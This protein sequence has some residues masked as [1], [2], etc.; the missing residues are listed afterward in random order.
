MTSEKTIKAAAKEME[1][2]RLAAR[3]EAEK[4][5]KAK[6]AAAEKE[7]KAAEKAR[8]AAAE[9]ARKE[10]EKAEKARFAAAEKVRKAVEKARLAAVEKARKEAENARNTEWLEN[11]LVQKKRSY[12][13]LQLAKA[14]LEKFGLDAKSAPTI[15]QV[16]K[17][18][19]PSL[20]TKLI[21]LSK[22]KVL[23]LAYNNVPQE[24]FVREALQ[25]PLALKTLVDD[26]PM[27]KPDF[28]AVLKRLLATGQVQVTKID[29]KFGITEIK[30]ATESRPSAVSQPTMERNDAELFQAAFDKLDGGRIFVRICNMRRELGWSEERFNAVLRKLRTDGTIQL[31]A[32]EVSTMTEEDI[33]LSY[34]DENNFFYATITWKKR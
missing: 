25:K 29:D 8:L 32:G 21:L 34:M 1:K 26:V 27:S 30:L 28:V 9:K 18:I 17:A 15:S 24:E 11:L 13:L 10:A 20:G 4:A 3:K 31:R 5:E 16:K 12:L 19:T 7:R 2:A 14:E 22:A 33:N 6:L 23:Y